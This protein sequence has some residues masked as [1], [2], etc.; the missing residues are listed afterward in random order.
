VKAHR[1]KEEKKLFDELNEYKSANKVMLD[2]V[3]NSRKSIQLLTDQ[4][5]AMR[6]RIK[7][8]KNNKGRLA[9]G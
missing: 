1:D 6:K 5:V 2:E 8:M 7:K 4:V 3:A 9:D